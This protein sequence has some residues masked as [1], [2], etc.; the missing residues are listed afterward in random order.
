[1]KKRIYLIIA[2][3][4]FAVSIY[5]INSIMLGKIP[6]SSS[7]V[8]ISINQGDQEAA[9]RGNTLGTGATKRME[10]FKVRSNEL[11][12]GGNIPVKYVCREIDG[13]DNVSIPLKWSNAPV[14]AR[15]FAVFM[16]DLNSVAKNFVHWAV[17]NIP[18][19]VSEILEGASRTPY[20]PTSSVEL[21]NSSGSIGYVGP[22]PPLGTGRH[23]YK[24][25]VYALNVETLPLSGYLTFKQ[26]ESQ[27]KGKVI[28]KAEMS[29]FF[30]R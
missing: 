21:K 2:L 27:I 18:Y 15:S 29:G 19:N 10:G 9:L 14:G 7:Q 20:M 8:Q 5:S 1:M 25:I 24:I 11:V 12:S 4:V 30:Q 13:G 26:F 28:A 22:C 3:A 6:V 16:Y 23:E 17:I